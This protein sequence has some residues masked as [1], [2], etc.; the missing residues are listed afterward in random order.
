MK[1]LLG[2]TAELLVY[3]IISFTAGAAAIMIGVIMANAASRPGA[4]D[5]WRFLALVGVL[6]AVGGLICLLYGVWQ[7]GRKIDALYTRVFESV[8]DPQQLAAERRENE[9]T[10]A[11]ENGIDT[12][13]PSKG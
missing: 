7:A 2:V 11:E 1:K 9:S 8:S 12:L 13:G 6:A 10:R 5:G 4:A 3:G